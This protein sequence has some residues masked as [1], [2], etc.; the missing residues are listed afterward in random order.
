MRKGEKLRPAGRE[1]RE[2]KLAIAMYYSFY[3]K[4]D[5][6]LAIALSQTIFNLT[7]SFIR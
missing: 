7:H 6:I 1:A 4:K 3:F 5:V 2:G